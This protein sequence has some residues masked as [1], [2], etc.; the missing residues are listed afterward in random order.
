MTTISRGRWVQLSQL[1]MDGP[2]KAAPRDLPYRNTG[3]NSQ[4]GP[5]EDV[6]KVGPPDGESAVVG[7]VGE[8]TGEEGTVSRLQFLGAGLRV[9]EIRQ[10]RN[11]DGACLFANMGPWGHMCRD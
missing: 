2:W 7:V 6:G 4:K 11:W 5:C 10:L 1:Y 8:Q 9:R 3:T